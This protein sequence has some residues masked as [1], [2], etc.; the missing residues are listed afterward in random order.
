M[1]PSRGRSACREGAAGTPSGMEHLC[2]RKQTAPPLKSFRLLHFHYRQP[3]NQGLLLGCVIIFILIK[4]SNLLR[5]C[6][7]TVQTGRPTHRLLHITQ[8]R[9]TRSL[10]QTRLSLAHSWHLEMKEA[11]SIFPINVRLP[12][13]SITAGWS[14][15]SPDRKAPEGQPGDA[16]EGKGGCLIQS[17]FVGLE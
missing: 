6:P 14:N 10:T 13:L 3:I 9:G 4:V 7:W 15:L 5:L 12:S 8:L 1:R 17:L 2:W 11:R 16:L